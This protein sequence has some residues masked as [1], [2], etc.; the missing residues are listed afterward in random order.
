MM[1]PLTEEQGKNIVLYLHSYAGLPGSDAIAGLS[2]AERAAKGLQNVRGF[3]RG[4]KLVSQP[5]Q[6]ELLL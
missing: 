4:S 2:K 3:Q 1:R 6:P 5:R